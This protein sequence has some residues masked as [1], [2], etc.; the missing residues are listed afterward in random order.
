[1]VKSVP[2]TLL[3]VESRRTSHHTEDAGDRIRDVG[4][5]ALL[6]WLAALHAKGLLRMPTESLGST[7][8]R[9]TTTI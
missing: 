8:V 2:A 1:M 4:T 9:L 3:L 6:G 5:L 7:T